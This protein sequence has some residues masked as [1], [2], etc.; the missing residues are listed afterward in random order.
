MNLEVNKA[1]ADYKRAKIFQHQEKWTDAIEDAKQ[2]KQ[3]GHPQADAL[4]RII[5]QN[6]SDDK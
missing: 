6:Q 2:A 5:E 1:K 3:L 4:I